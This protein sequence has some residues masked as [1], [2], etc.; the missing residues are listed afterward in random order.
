MDPKKQNLRFY[1]SNI[2]CQQYWSSENVCL[3]LKVLMSSF[4]TSEAVGRKFFV[5]K[6]FLKILQN[7]LKNIRDTVFNLIKFHAKGQQLYWKET[8]AYGIS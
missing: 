5:E 8:P 3:E 6:V 2:A 7:P 4:S 1:S